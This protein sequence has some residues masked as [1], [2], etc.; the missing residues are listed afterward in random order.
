MLKIAADSSAAAE[1]IYNATYY[2]AK[3]SRA[4]K[5]KTGLLTIGLDLSE[6]IS[7]TEDGRIRRT[8]ET[9]NDAPELVSAFREQDVPFAL[10]CAGVDQT[11]GGC[12]FVMGL[13]KTVRDLKA[14]DTHGWGVPMHV[15]LAAVVA[16]AR[17]LGLIVS[18]ASGAK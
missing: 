11:D 10:E 12:P 3:P 18:A 13:I 16:V 17:E 5:I 7:D 6:V 9:L 4:K 1:K 8:V 15:R 14:S 2:A